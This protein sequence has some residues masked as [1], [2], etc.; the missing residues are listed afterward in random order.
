MKLSWE[1]QRTLDYLRAHQDRDGTTTVAL[2]PWIIQQ[3]GTTSTLRWRIV[4]ELEA[5]GKI[6]R[7]NPKS[8][9]IQIH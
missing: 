8:R 6:T 1:A 3:F 7:T 5:A 4:K 2:R 9:R